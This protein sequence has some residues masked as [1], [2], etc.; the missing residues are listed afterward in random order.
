MALL[1]VENDDSFSWNVIDLLPVPRS[2]I[3][4]RRAHELDGDAA[5]LRHV[6]ALVIGPGP[7]DP[8]RAGLLELVG[9]AARQGLPLLGVCL[10]HQAIGLAFGARLERVRP[11][12][13]QVSQV[14]FGPSRLFPE[15]IG[16]HELMRY[17]SLALTVVVP[18]LR[19][20][21]TTAEG[22]VMALEHEQLPIAGL[23]FHPDSYASP[24]G[25]AIVGDFF[26]TA[27]EQRR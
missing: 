9:A 1:F 15:T 24:S 7:T 26:R 13:G 8:Q 10:G 11:W 16:P 25:R 4:V 22:T 6:E 2:A 23:Q 27:L 18:P 21:A 12:H 17:H 3:R 20:I 14:T 5:A 19:V